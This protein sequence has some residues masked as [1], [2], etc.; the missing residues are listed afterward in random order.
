MR[1]AVPTGSHFVTMTDE[2]LWKPDSAN[3]LS[4]RRTLDGWG[5]SPLDQILWETNLSA[6]V[7]GYPITF[8]VEGKQ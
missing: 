3:W 8:A 2:M 4:W 6:P 7:S 5:Y 1:P